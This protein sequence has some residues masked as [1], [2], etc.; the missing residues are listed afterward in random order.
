MEFAKTPFQ[1]ERH[2][3]LKDKG[4]QAPGPGES[5]SGKGRGRQQQGRRAGNERTR[6][7][8]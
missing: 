4:H 7:L 8:Q 1:L 6:N 5:R 2:V 3:D